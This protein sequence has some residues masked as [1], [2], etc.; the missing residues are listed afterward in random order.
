MKVRKIR[1]YESD[2][3]KVTYDQGRCIHAGAGIQP[4]NLFVMVPI[5]SRISQHSQ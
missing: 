1:S 5:N 4:T 2:D 3:I